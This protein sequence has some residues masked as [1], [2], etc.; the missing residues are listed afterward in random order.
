MRQK[1]F[2]S[3]AVLLLWGVSLRAQNCDKIMLPYFGYD[4]LR[5]QSYPDEKL[6]ERCAYAHLSFTV[7]DTLPQGAA[8]HDISEV[9]DK[10]TGEAIPQDIVINLDELSYFQYDFQ[11][12]R[13]LHYQQTV[14][15]RTPGSEHP[16]LVLRSF[17]ENDAL[18]N[19]WLRDK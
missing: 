9:L 4:E 2:F 6:A 8:V 19:K 5:L 7:A 15:F 17:R 11:R 16:Y 14:Y 10:F 1:L 13:G 12:F 3:I 18:F